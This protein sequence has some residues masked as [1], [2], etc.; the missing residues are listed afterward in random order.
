MIKAGELREKIT[1]K[2]PVSTQN[3]SGGQATGYAT[4]L[5]TFAR[6][7]ELSSD[8]ALIAAQ[9]SI[10]QVIE[11][12]MRYRPVNPVVNGD[13]IHWRSFEYVVNNIQ[14]DPMRTY[15]LF[16][17]VSSVNTSHRQ[18]NETEYTP[19][20]Y[21][22][23]GQNLNELI[24]Q[25]DGLAVNKAVDN[26]DVNAIEIGDKIWGFIDNEFVAG[27]VTGLPYTDAGNIDKAASGTIL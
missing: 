26:E 18:L 8:P 9:E 15:I 14:V 23:D 11:I 21:S 2:R 22:P 17:L 25:I 1:I 27:E 12:L 5:S 19:F 3:A 4:V 13:V 20:P 10:S 24:I 6:I 7:R 16:H